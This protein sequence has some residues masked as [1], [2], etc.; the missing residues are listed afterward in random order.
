MLRIDHRISHQKN[1][2]NPKIISQE[3]GCNFRKSVLAGAAGGGFR[4]QF[5]H[6]GGWNW[7]LATEEMRWER[8]QLNGRPRETAEGKKS[9]GRIGGIL[10]P[11]RRWGHTCN[12]IKG[13][14]F[15]YVFGGYGK[16]N[17]QT[18]DIHV[19]DT[20]GCLFEDFFFLSGAKNAWS[21]PMVKGN[22]PIPRDSHS[23]TTVGNNLFVFGGT[24]G[25]KPLN[26]LHIFDTSS[27]T[28]I[29]PNVSGE[30]PEAREGHSA[31][32]V[33]KRIFIFGGC[34][35]SHYEPEEVYYNDVY[36]LDT[37]YLV[38]KRAITTGSPPSARDSHTCSSWKNKI[39][40]IG[41]E[42]ASD[43]YLSTVHILDAA[44][45]GFKHSSLMFEVSRNSDWRLRST[46]HFSDG[47]RFLQSDTLVW[48]ELNTS[49]HIL[50]PRAGHSTVALGNHL[51]VFGGFTDDRNL[52]DDLHILNVDTAVWSKVANAGVG[53]SAR[54]SVAGD[55]LDPQKGILVFIGG[56]NQNLEALDDMYYLY[57]DM[58]VEIVQ[59]EQVLEKFSFRRELKRKCQDQSLLPATRPENDKDFPKLMMMP[60][61]YQPLPLQSFGQPGM[62]NFSSAYE[63]K[64]A[65]ENMF[66][67]KVTGASHYGY[68]IETNIDGKLLR[69]ILLS[70]KASFNPASDAYASRKRISVEGG[71]VK[72]NDGDHSPKSKTARVVEQDIERSDRSQNDDV[73]SKESTSESNN[74]T[75][76][77]TCQPQMV[78]L[79]HDPFTDTLEF[80]SGKDSIDTVTSG[81]DS[82]DTVTSG[83]DSID[84]LRAELSLELHK[85]IPRKASDQDVLMPKGPSIF[86]VGRLETSQEWPKTA[87]SSFAQAHRMN[88]ANQSH[89]EA[90]EQ[91]ID[92][93]ADVYVR[94]CKFM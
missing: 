35:K 48:R 56:C 75:H 78:S 36:I 82:I 22:P 69:G 66:E 15:L 25:T 10:G 63:L 88:V 84:T 12:S 44:L 18:N 91:E 51:F 32:L 57:T 68:A 92:F 86:L 65:G 2:K 42:D 5:G 39:I 73:H 43:Y 40:I 76:V 38:W 28:W 67:A 54:F 58:F 50:T 8:V 46:M 29:T 64:P 20:G 30:G 87:D 37:E 85:D 89:T 1:L 77:D 26:D 27:N 17:C 71:D 81:K 11:G 60:N 16:D 21:R 93:N 80:T 74:S 7:V 59:G 90:A 49:G 6:F 62:Q 55:C 47:Y 53:P 94:R 14:R 23:C 19:F 24:D 70:Y 83:K 45:T 72:S 31:A 4:G 79:Q 61:T 33:G 52:Y 13:G 3:M 41:G 34:G 9:P